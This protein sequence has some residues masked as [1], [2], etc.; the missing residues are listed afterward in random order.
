M[1]AL[2]SRIL[3]P[4]RDRLERYHIDTL[5]DVDLRD[6]RRPFFIDG[7]TEDWPARRWAR[8]WSRQGLVEVL[9]GIAPFH[10]H[11]AYNQ[12]LAELFRTRDYVMTHSMLGDDSCYSDPWRPYSPLLLSPTVLGAIRVPPLLRRLSTWQMGVGRR[13]GL[14]VPPEDHPASWFVT[15]VGRKRWVVHPPNASGKAPSYL[16]RRERNACWR[17]DALPERALEFDQLEGDLLWLPDYWQHETCGLD[18]LSL[19]VGGLLTS[20]ERV[21]GAARGAFPGGCA[22]ADE[23]RSYTV[24]DIP[25]CAPPGVCPT[26]ADW[27]AV[28]EGEA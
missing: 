22:G 21:R 12:T 8:L 10:L 14:G 16:Q 28:M 15:V 2:P 26:L 19:G 9:D 5:R 6:A 24:A 27:D 17:D 1:S 7:V 13:R 4:P 3:L 25:A 18:D 23:G 11:A 20:D